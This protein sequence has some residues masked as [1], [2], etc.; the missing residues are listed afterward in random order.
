MRLPFTKIYLQC[1]LLNLHNDFYLNLQ[2]LTSKKSDIVVLGNNSQE[3]NTKN[4]KLFLLR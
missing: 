2:S 1:T 3:Y 4:K